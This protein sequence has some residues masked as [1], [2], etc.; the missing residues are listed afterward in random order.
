MVMHIL[1]P[2]NALQYY[3]QLNK[4]LQFQISYANLLFAKLTMI[5]YMLCAVKCVAMAIMLLLTCN[6]AFAIYY[7]S[8]VDVCIKCDC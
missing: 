3:L 8:N 7:T 6:F 2:S 1:Y 5:T 4:I